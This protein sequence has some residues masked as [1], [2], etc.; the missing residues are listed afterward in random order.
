MNKPEMICEI[1]VA[2]QDASVRLIRFNAT[3]DAAED[4]RQFGDVARFLDCKDTYM[5]HVDARYNFSEVLAYIEQYG[6]DTPQ[7]E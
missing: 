5:L 6:K 2:Y 7:P 1:A 3:S 4:M